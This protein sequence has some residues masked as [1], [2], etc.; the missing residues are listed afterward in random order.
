MQ[1]PAVDQ[2]HCSIGQ[3]VTPC[4]QLLPE[5]RVAPPVTNRQAGDSAAQ[6]TELGEMAAKGAAAVKHQHG[7]GVTME[8]I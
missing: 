4:S 8:G 2:E 1:H 6:L 7:S 3:V 5:V